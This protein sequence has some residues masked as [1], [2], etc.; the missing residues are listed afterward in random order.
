MRSKTNIFFIL[1]FVLSVIWIVISSRYSA[2]SVNNISFSGAESISA[3]HQFKD[4]RHL[5]V[6][7][8]ALGNPCQRLS[9]ESIVRESDPEQ[10]TIL[11]ST[12]STADTCIQV[13]TEEQFEVT[14]K[15]SREAHISALLN[16]A[17]IGMELVSANTD[18]ITKFKLD[19]AR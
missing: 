10:V 19:M 14:F 1:L 6:G 13:V 12:E 11:L 4:G 15:A 17:P 8:I 18:E 3:L 7:K 5:I 16:G 9:V 2:P